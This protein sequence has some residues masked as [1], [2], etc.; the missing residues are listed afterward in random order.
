[1]FSF[2]SSKDRRLPDPRKSVAEPVHT[3]RPWPFLA[4]S[5][6]VQRAPPRRSLSLPQH[7]AIFSDGSSFNPQQLARASIA[8]GE[9]AISSAEGTPLS[10]NS[11]TRGYFRQDS[12]L[13]NTSSGSGASSGADGMA[14]SRSNSMASEGSRSPAMV[15]EDYRMEKRQLRTSLVPDLY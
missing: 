13:A 10:A 4:A 8:G 2:F 1:M 15:A 3:A 11:P 14:L 5:P 6:P 7:V 12:F 9:S